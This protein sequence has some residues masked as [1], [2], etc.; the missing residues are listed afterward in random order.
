M[1]STRFGSSLFSVAEIFSK[2]K[3][4]HNRL[5]LSGHSGGG[6]QPLYFCKVDVASCF[7]TIPQ[8]HLL[9]LVDRLLSMPLYYLTK[10]AEISL[11]SPPQL[12]HR[13][14]STCDPKLGLLET[15]STSSSVT[16]TDHIPITRIKTL[17]RFPDGS[18]H[19]SQVGRTT[20]GR[21]NTV[22][23]GSIGESSENRTRILEL[24]HDHI[25]FNLVKVGRKYYRQKSGIPQGSVVSALLC[26]F[27]Y[28]DFEQRHLSF[29]NGHEE[30][31]E[32]NRGGE[33]LLMRLLDDFLL[34][35]TSR[36]K[37]ERFMHVLHAGNKDFD[38]EVKREKSLANFNISVG[39]Q[40][41]PTT[42]RGTKGFPYCGISIDMKTLEVRKHADGKGNAT[43]SDSLTIDVAKRPGQAFYRKMVK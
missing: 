21:R 13:S 28:A 5:R 14:A 33:S 42:P 39:G 34:V 29:I 37:A 8:E 27:F 41:I 3:T 36:A 26:N 12:A 6:G 23:V 10:H 7:D 25:Q 43:V 19:A 38:I 11:A 16:A 15:R 1:Q 9:S 17:N 4:F 20:A 32:S 35:T 40:K 2:I 30:E 24:L 18:I 31:E 22:F